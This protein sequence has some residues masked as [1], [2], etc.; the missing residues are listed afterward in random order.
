MELEHFFNVKFNLNNLT[1]CA[2]ANMICYERYGNPPPISIIILCYSC[3]NWIIESNESQNS[4]ENGSDS[5][6]NG[7]ISSR[8]CDVTI[9]GT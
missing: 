6:W 8:A 3:I 1:H 2:I 7:P 4:A 9:I 5:N